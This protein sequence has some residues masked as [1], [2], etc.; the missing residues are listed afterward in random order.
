[1]LNIILF[2]L[3]SPEFIT[4]LTHY[5]LIFSI[6]FKNNFLI[7]STIPL[8]LTNALYISLTMLYIFDKFDITEEEE[9]EGQ[10][11]LQLFNEN[12]YT[13]K[14]FVILT[15]FMIPFYIVFNNLHKERKKESNIILSLLI[16]S[17]IIFIYSTYV[18]KDIYSRV[19]LHSKDIVYIIPTYLLLNL[20]ITV[21]YFT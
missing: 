13:F 21:F 19:N 12:I 10:K 14:L 17:I 16:S 15:H 6:I 4:N 2:L 1:M 5:I 8:C 3:F 7:N 11:I 9:K 20:L 18:D